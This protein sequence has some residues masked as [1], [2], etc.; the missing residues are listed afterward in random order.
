MKILI[1]N[2]RLIDYLTDFDDVTDI[3]IQDGIIKEIGTELEDIA[4]EVIDCTGLCVIPGMVDMHCHLREPGYEYKENIESGI[5]SAAAGGFTSIACMPNTN[6]V[7]DNQAIAMFI[8]E[9]A[10]SIGKVNVFP[11]GCITKGQNGQELAEIADMKQAGVVAISD[12][13]K[14]VTNPLL[15]RRALQ[16]A[17][18]FELSVISHCED[19]ELVDEGVMN[20]GYVSTILGLKGIPREAEEV[21]VARDVIL[22]ENNDCH[23][24]IAHISTKGSVEI[25]RNAKKRNVKVTAE[26]CPHYFSLTDEAVTGFI[27]A[28][29]V[30]PPLRT[31]EDLE[32]IKKG[33]ADGTIDVIATDHAPHHIDD[34]NVEFNSAAFGISGFETALS[35]CVTNLLQTKVLTYKQLAEKICY[36]PSK[37]LGLN[38]GTISIGS[39]ADITIF[40]PNDEII[41]DAEKFISKGKN[42]PFDGHKLYGKVCYTIVDGKIV[43]NS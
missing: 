35:L 2:A 19:K 41:V 39:P 11:I 18:M 8:K 21:M 5:N 12:D 36:N 7:I 31:E 28:A 15:M 23:V 20:E 43:C 24:H 29:K 30:N 34:K 3:Y 32:A 40:A 10:K 6:P 4:D 38:R 16:Y 33:L 13:G 14:P 1:K 9:K 25:V 42:T 27:T 26:T 17:K 37:I 22:A